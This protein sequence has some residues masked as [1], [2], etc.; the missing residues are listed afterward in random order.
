[1]GLFQWR[2][3]GIF[4]QCY[5]YCALSGWRFYGGVLCIWNGPAYAVLPLMVY[6]LAGMGTLPG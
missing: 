2:Q 4:G 1:M 6:M 5:A 3:G